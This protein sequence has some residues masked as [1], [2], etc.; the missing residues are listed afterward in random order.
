MELK[1]CITIPPPPF[2]VSYKDRLL[3][4]GSCFSENIGEKLTGL[5]FQ[6]DINPFG[7]LYNPLSI[8]M[9]VDILKKKKN[10]TSEDL[11]FS[12]GFY[13]SMDH[14]SRFSSVFEEDC[15]SV[16]NKRIELSSKALKK[17]D[18]IFIT[19][20]TRYVYTDKSTG[21]VV[22]NCHKLPE[23]SFNRFSLDVT[24]ITEASI[25]LISSL[26]EI[27]PDI[28]CIFTV[29]PIRHWKDGAHNNQLSKAALLLS[30]DAIQKRYPSSVAY[31]PAYEILMDELRDYRFYADD[32][33][34][35]SSL[36]IA[37]IWQRFTET[38]IHPDS[39]SIMKE[40]INIVKAIQHKPFNPKSEQYRNF[41]LQTLLKMERIK[42]KFPY[43]DIETELNT[44]KS[45]LN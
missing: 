43:F 18:I 35:P 6:A 41:I 36:A 9:A 31:F 21:K 42:E 11:I 5:K 15:L 1:T 32:M 39:V 37:Y 23:A 7:T 44:L 17:T 22:A 19:Y 30:I 34:H 12:K 8:C 3:L 13:H 16:I 14:H 27:N 38:F 28:K 29:S 26:K 24:D 4:L 45:K 2:Q 10:Y 25:N 40:W 33:F 20:G